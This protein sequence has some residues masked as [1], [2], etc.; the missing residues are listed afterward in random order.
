MTKRP[1]LDDII[2][3]LFDDRL[4]RDVEVRGSDKT[5]NAIRADNQGARD[6]SEKLLHAAE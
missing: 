5:G 2:S 6:W 3:E 4:F 1:T